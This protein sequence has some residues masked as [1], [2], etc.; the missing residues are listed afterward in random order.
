MAASASAVPRFISSTVAALNAQEALA[1]WADEVRLVFF[2]E[3]LFFPVDRNVS[4]WFRPH[5]IIPYIFGKN[6]KVKGV[7]V[8]RKRDSSIFSE[9]SNRKTVSIRFD[10]K[11]RKRHLCRCCLFEFDDLRFRMVP[12]INAAG[13]V[14]QEAQASTFNSLSL[15][16][17]GLD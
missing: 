7:W 6:C 10:K 14:S 17:S 12:W 13:M 8:K 16:L 2:I 11:E 3:L 9:K 4:A 5:L 1:S 15:S